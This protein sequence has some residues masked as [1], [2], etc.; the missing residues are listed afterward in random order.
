[1]KP[2]EI[3]PSISITKSR[4]SAQKC[5]ECQEPIGKN[6][7]FNF[8]NYNDGLVLK[9]NVWLHIKCFPA[10]SKRLKKYLDEHGAEIGAKAI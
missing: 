4:G 6:I 7:G 8:H 10:F 1:M 5:I 9:K 2:I 3:T